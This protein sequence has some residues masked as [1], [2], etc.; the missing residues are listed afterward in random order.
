MGFVVGGPARA[1]TIGRGWANLDLLIGSVDFDGDR[2]TDV[3]A[4]DREGNLLLYPGDG[5][6]GWRESSVVGK[7]WSAMDTAFYA[8]DFDGN[9]GGGDILARRTDGTLWLYS[10]T[11]TGSWG[12]ARQ[13]G[14]G[15]GGMAQIISPGDFDG[16]GKMDVLA[17]TTA[18]ELLLYRGD[19]RGGWLGSRVV[20]KGWVT[21]EPIG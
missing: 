17:R 13:I 21:V 2:N 1:P 18:G 12:D 14:K 3:L 20:G 11:G 8:G 19:G 10:L 4:R 6:G 7:G 9:G 5:N 15:W 16:D